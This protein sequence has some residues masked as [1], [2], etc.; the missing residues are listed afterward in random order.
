[1]TERRQLGVMLIPAP[2]PCLPDDAHLTAVYAGEG[3]TDFGVQQLFRLTQMMAIRTEPFAAMVLGLNPNFGEN[4]D[5]P[6]ILLGLT[7]ELASLY[8]VLVP[9]SKSSYTEF[10][11]HIAVPDINFYLGHGWKIPR[12]IYFNRIAVWLDSKPVVD[13]YLGTGTKAP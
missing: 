5:E 12:H 2:L 10:R 13:L 1:M 11:P 6:V 8:S 4:K 9:H 3:A 7:P